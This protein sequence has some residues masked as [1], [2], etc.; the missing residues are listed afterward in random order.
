MRHAFASAGEV[1]SQRPLMPTAV[2]HCMSHQASI[3]AAADNGAREAAHRAPAQA[4]AGL[5]QGGS[6]SR[7]DGSKGTSP[8]WVSSPLLFGFDGATC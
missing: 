4:C 2:D 3:S 7:G 5:E 1:P 6:T 8:G